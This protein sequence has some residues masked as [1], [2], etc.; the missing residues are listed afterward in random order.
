MIVGVVVGISQISSTTDKGI[1]YTPTPVSAA[2]MHDLTHVPLS[3]YNSAGT[4]IAGLNYVPKVETGQKPLTLQGKPG[5]FVLLGEFCPFCAAERWSIITSLSRFGTFSGLR[6]MQSAP[7]D[8][9]P[10]T[11]T[12]TFNGATY[13]SPYISARL[14]EA[15]GQEKAT[16]HRPLIHKPTRADDALIAKYDIS[17]TTR[18]GNIPFVDVGNKVIFSGASFN[19]QPLQT[20]SRKTIAAALK[21]PSNSVGKMV[22]GTSN[23]MSAAICSI[24]GG[25][26]G[27]VCSSAGVKA[28][29]SALKISG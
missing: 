28:A 26:P 23:Y 12:F 14:L 17:S 16:G 21:N 11:Q 1:I 2:V 15:Y 18:S 25:K 7:K 3:A 24:D 5:L 27:A 20:L 22:L 10:K 6:T 8:V 13:T 29:A 19:P 4:G 9:Y